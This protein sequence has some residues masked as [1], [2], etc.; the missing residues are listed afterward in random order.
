MNLSV[1]CIATILTRYVLANPRDDCD[2]ERLN[3]DLL[4]LSLRLQID[5]IV[6]DIL[7]SPPQSVLG[8]QFETVTVDSGNCIPPTLTVLEPVF[9]FLDVEP[10]VYYTLALLE[11]DLPSAPGPTLRS[12]IL[13]LSVNMRGQP[14]EPFGLSS[15]FPLCP[16]GAIAP[17]LGS[18]PHRALG[19]VY[20]QPARID[21]NSR[22]L[23]N[24]SIERVQ[25]DLEQFVR[26]Y[27]LGDPVAANYWI[28]DHCCSVNFNN[29]CNTN[30]VCCNNG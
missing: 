6:P 14:G 26:N 1:L 16:Y 21:T 12:A 29:C 8:I 22:S 25:F 20:Q 11:L 30:E 15:G 9:E 7:S 3:D 10:N 18:G 24:L 2:T 13:G 19:V 27:T 4:K 23:I 17:L 28:S 5:N